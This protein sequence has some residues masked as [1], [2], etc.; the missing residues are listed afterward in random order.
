MRN[1]GS[2]DAESL[3]VIQADAIRRMGDTGDAERLIAP[4]LICAMTLPAAAR[5]SALSLFLS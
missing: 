3:K 4:S 5:E 2:E 1:L